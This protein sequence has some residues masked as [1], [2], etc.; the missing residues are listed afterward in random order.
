[1]AEHASGDGGAGGDGGGSGSDCGG[2]AA[3][4]NDAGDGEATDDEVS[5]GG[6]RVRREDVQRRLDTS[7]KEAT[8]NKDVRHT[9][10]AIQGMSVRSLRLVFEAGVGVQTLKLEA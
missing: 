5:G 8:Q 6:A 7:T 9:L 4:G 10:N 2:R 3:V 1:M